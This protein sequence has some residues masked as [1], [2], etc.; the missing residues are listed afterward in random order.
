MVHTRTFELQV[1]ILVGRLENV[2]LWFRSLQNLTS[3]YLHWSRLEE[4]LVPHI[5][6]LPNLGKL[7]LVNA[8]VGKQLHFQKGF[9]KLKTLALH[10]HPLLTDIILDKG[11][12][13]Y[14]PLGKVWIV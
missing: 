7:Y 6:A 4:N 1:V 8:Y 12:T 13:S 5:E 11:K 3:L 9:V 10:N 2:P 14:G